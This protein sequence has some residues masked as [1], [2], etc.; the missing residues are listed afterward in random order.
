MFSMGRVKTALDLKK[1]SPDG[2]KEERAGMLPQQGHNVQ[3]AA[4]GLKGRA[5]T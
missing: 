5:L 1:P 2:F 4:G 3:R